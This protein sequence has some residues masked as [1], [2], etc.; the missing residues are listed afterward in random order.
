MLDT[1]APDSQ[2]RYAT[3]ESRFFGGFYSPVISSLRGGG[4][5]QDF[6]SASFTDSLRFLGK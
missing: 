3:I 2:R 5:G 6:W 4:D 1:S